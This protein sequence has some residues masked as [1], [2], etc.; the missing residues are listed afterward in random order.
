ML[1]LLVEDDPVTI[2]FVSNG[3]EIWPEGYRDFNMSL[4][5][6]KRIL[7]SVILDLMYGRIL[8]RESG[9]ICGGTN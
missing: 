5:L 9:I 4:R 1:F 8:S 7:Q 2:G 6:S 3:G